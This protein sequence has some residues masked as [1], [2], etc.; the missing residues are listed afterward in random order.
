M[1][2]HYA[3]P[4]TSKLRSVA[5]KSREKFFFHGHST[6]TPFRI[7]RYGTELIASARS[8]TARYN[9]ATC[10]YPTSAVLIVPFR[11]N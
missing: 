1:R 3:A 4:V 8:S 10:A 5:A 11:N 2:T 9:G 7:N 6:S